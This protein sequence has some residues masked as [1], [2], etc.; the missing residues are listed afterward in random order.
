[1]GKAPEKVKKYEDRVMDVFAFDEDD[2]EA[3]QAGHLSQKQQVRLKAARNR[4]I[5]AFALVSMLLGFLAFVFIAAGF[6][7]S[8]ILLP[9]AAGFLAVLGTYAI[10]G[11]RAQAFRDEIRENRAAVVEGRIELLLNGTQ[12]GSEYFL[13]VENLRFTVK[14]AA[15]L[16]FKNGDPY[17]IYYTPRSKQILSVEWLRED[18]NLIDKDA[19]A[20]L[21]TDSEHDPALHETQ[22]DQSSISTAN[23]P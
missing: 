12:Y 19:R 14:Q 21:Q 5:S 8:N 10:Y 20:D 9:L 6:Q 7:T 23:A 16:A 11:R 4:A 22:D 17:R 2:F 13:C 15:F 18:D 1:M 3:N